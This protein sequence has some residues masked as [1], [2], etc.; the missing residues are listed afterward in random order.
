MQ[1]LI[2]FFG[3][4]VFG[5]LL[6][7]SHLSS[8]CPFSSWKVLL[9]WKCFRSDISWNVEST[10]WHEAI[11]EMTVKLETNTGHVLAVSHV[12]IAYI[13]SVRWGGNP[14]V[15]FLCCNAMHLPLFLI[16]FLFL[17]NLYVSNA[18]RYQLILPSCTASNFTK[19]INISWARCCCTDWSDG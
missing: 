7:N 3:N 17:I 4:I 19:L 1:Y 5:L 6:F 9:M 11:V 18:G 8:F 2:A 14:M 15:G 12:N 16:C 10:L 13:L